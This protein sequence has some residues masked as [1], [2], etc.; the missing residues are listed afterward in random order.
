MSSS[1][2]RHDFINWMSSIQG[3]NAYFG[4]D[5]MQQW[6]DG[7][8][9]SRIYDDLFNQWMNPATDK[10]RLRDSLIGRFTGS[11]PR[12][13]N[14]MAK[15]KNSGDFQR[16]L[17]AS[18]Q[19]AVTDSQNQVTMW[20]NI[21]NTT[22]DPKESA[23]ATSLLTSYTSQLKQQSETLAQYQKNLADGL[24]SGIYQ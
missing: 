1:N 3:A 8:I 7:L 23:F 9:A 20:Q 15:A 18:I 12:Y 16:G 17:I 6:A 5:K 22:K 11:N 21:V 24:L 10:S 14:Y 13:A 19:K 2:G 4:L